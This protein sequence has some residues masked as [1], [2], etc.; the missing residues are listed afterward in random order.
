MSDWW[1]VILVLAVAAAAFLYF[2][3]KRKADEAQRNRPANLGPNHDFQKARDDAR[4]SGMSQE[5]QDWQAASLQR[6][7]ETEERAAKE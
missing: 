5:D 4:T 2:S 3:R 7:K 6:N 1:Y